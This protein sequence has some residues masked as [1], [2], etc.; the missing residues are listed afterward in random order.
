MCVARN[1]SSIDVTQAKVGTQLRLCSGRDH[2]ADCRS[3]RF[4]NFQSSWFDQGSKLPEL[5]HKTF[6]LLEL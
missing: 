4:V 2:F 6:A 1:K 5:S 3:R